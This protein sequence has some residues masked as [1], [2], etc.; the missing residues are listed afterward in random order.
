MTQT[1]QCGVSAQTAGLP[2]FC[3]GSIS[4]YKTRYLPSVKVLAHNLIHKRC[5]EH[6]CGDKYRGYAVDETDLRPNQAS[7]CFLRSKNFSFAIKDLS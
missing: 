5:A 6:R 4:P 2:T 3:A 7:A 1:V